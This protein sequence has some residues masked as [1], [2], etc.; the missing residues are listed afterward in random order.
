VISVSTSNETIYEMKRNLQ[1]QGTQHIVSAASMIAG[2]QAILSHPVVPYAKVAFSLKGTAVNEPTLIIQKAGAQRDLLVSDLEEQFLD[3]S[4][5]IGQHR[6]SVESQFDLT[7]SLEAFNNAAARNWDVL[8]ERLDVGS[9][10]RTT[11][12]CHRRF[13]DA[14]RELQAPFCEAMCSQNATCSCTSELEEDAK[15]NSMKELMQALAEKTC[16][17]NS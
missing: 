16:G 4:G 1:L 12:E 7:N 6:A 9:A 5:N 15:S 11:E 2:V 14:A 8:R 10:P 13:G 17:E 3:V